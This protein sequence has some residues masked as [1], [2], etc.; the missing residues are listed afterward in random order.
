MLINF[1]IFLA[2]L[3]KISEARS[4]WRRDIFDNGVE[5]PN[6]VISHLRRSGGNLYGEPSS[7]TGHKVSQWHAG[8][9][10]NPEEL[11]DYVEGDIL[12]PGDPGHPMA[13]NGLKDSSA[14]WPG[15]V[16]PYVISP[17]FGRVYILPC[18]G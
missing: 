9:D 16:I 5:D 6:G 12:F 17:A 11:G 10:V 8:M 14:R 13:R 4:N 15:G 7:Q 3:L 18:F 2:L 1:V